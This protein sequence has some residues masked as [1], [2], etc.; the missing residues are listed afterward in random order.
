MIE[1]EIYTPGGCEA[2]WL[3]K[4]YQVHG[5]P[6]SYLAKPPPKVRVGSAGFSPTRHAPKPSL[7][8]LPLLTPS[9]SYSRCRNRGGVFGVC[10]MWA[11]RTAASQS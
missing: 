4:L 10:S 9:G 3:S 1:E 11:G 5:G 6:S 7:R 2:N 8:A